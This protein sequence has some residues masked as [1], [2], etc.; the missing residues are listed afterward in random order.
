MNRSVRIEHECENCAGT[1]LYSG[2]GEQNGAA[3]VCHGC[4]GTGKV[5]FEKTFKLFSRRQK[6]KGVKRVFQCNPGITIG[7]RKAGKGGPLKLKDFGGIS[8]E[9]W[10]AG[11]P[12][13]PGTE[14]RRF[15]CPAW[16]YQSVD[17]KRKPGWKECGSVG[18]FSNCPSFKNKSKC[19][20]RF[21]KEKL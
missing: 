3:V 11:K 4:T 10:K 12:F 9:G 13:G 7:E 8:P 17:Y 5:I 2:F 21:D 20:E 14:M 19:W 15:V 1:G 6:T 18:S 16:W